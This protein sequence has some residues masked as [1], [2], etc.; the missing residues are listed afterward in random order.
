MNATSARLLALAAAGLF[1]T[2]GAGIK[3]AAFTGPQIASLRA[4]IAALALLL[5]LRGRVAWSARAAAVGGIYAITTTLFVNA[6]KLTTAAN[7]IFLQATAPLHIL[8]LGPLLI[9]ETFHRRDVLYLLAV[10]SGL[11]LAFFGRPPA[12]T[13]APNPA[14]GNV[15]AL[16]CSVMWALTLLGLRRLERDDS[17]RGTGI[18]AMIAGNLFACVVP[19]SFIWPLPAATVADWATIVFL[20]VFQIG[21]AYVCL[22]AAMKRLPALEASLLL[23]LEPILSPVWTWIVHG[24]H[25]GNAVLT[26]GAIIVSATALKTYFDPSRRASARAA[27]TTP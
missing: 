11:V 7:A 5:W 10:G 16:I 9:G 26:G 24:E 21:L 25:P 12:T 4:G 23:L 6:N 19:L 1:S 8:L 3:A 14:L 13:T 18:A 20:G 2:G 22:T 15:L 17:D 27:H